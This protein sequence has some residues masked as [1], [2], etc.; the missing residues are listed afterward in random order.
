MIVRIIVE[1]F[2]NDMLIFIG[3]YYIG[4]KSSVRALDPFELKT[5]R[6][7]IKVNVGNPDFLSA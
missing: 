1:F 5:S 4:E 6:I 7:F 2:E 3:P